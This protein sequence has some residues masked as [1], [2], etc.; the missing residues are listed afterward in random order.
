M[1]ADELPATSARPRKLV[2]GLKRSGGEVILT[3]NTWQGFLSQ[4]M[5]MTLAVSLSLRVI[6]LIDRV[7]SD[8]L[9]C[10]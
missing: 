9:N 8:T 6:L 5:T 2:G 7:M 10:V 4:T 3:H 1:P